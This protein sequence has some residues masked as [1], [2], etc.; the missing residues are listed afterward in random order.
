MSPILA[1]GFF[2]FAIIS[3][4]FVPLTFAGKAKIKGGQAAM[5]LFEH[6]SN[7]LKGKTVVWIPMA[8][9]FPLMDGWTQVMKEEAKNVGF[10]F[11]MRDGNWD[12]NLQQQA[13][14][15]LIPQK[16]DIMIVHPPDVSVLTNLIKKAEKAGI[17]VIQVNMLS[18]YVSDGYV[19][20]NWADVGRL[21]A[22]E[23][24]KKCG[25]GTNTSHKVAINQG[26]ESSAGNIYQLQ[27]A[28]KVF[29]THPDI[30]IVANLPTGWLSKKAYENTAVII[31]KHPD[32]C[33]SVGFWGFMQLGAIQAI[34]EAKLTG[35][36]L[37]YAGGGGSQVICDNV[38]DGG[39]SAYWNFDTMGQGRDIINMAK[40]LL[41]SDVPPGG[42]TQ[43]LF[44]PISVITKENA[45][46]ACWVYQPNKGK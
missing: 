8:L 29:N 14:N 5:K 7:T 28:M 33:A 4:F 19:G 38:A 30:K 37:V 44:S 17:Y 41:Q 1:K 25:K 45:D 24:V 16:P 42:H 18:K 11:I 35:K 43:A 2:I 3:F 40:I 21:M 46:T 27:G 12:S 9:G 15:A 20:V 34:K 10:N 23:V 32:L 36:V 6:Y 13:M 22:E 39:F 31:Q 26:E